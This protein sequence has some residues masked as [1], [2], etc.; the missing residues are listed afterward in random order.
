MLIRQTSWLTLLAGKRKR[1]SDATDA[2]PAMPPE[3]DEPNK[4]PKGSKGHASKTAEDDASS[5]ES[6][7]DDGKETAKILKSLQF[8]EVEG[9]T[10]SASMCPKI[11]KCLTKRL[12][13]L[14]AHVKSFP[15][16]AAMTQLQKS[17]Q[18]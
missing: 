4:K 2:S 15:A 7:S 10:F 13:K 17:F 3:P 11:Q 5:I 6:D 18:S 12:T 9:G 8:P 1:K 16:R 14:E